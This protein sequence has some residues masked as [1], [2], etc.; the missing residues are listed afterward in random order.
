MAAIKLGIYCHFK[1]NLYEVLDTAKHSETEE[2]YVVYRPVREGSETWIRPL[3][4]FSEI[5]EREGKKIARF[6]YVSS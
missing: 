5:I 6:E 3:A 2:V 1:G 4:M